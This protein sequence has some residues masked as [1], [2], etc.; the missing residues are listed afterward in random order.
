MISTTPMVD[1]EGQHQRVEKIWFSSASRRFHHW[2]ARS[3]TPG[4][5]SDYVSRAAASAVPR[6]YSVVSQTGES[7]PLLSLQRL[8]A[9]PE[10]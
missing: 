6:L 8:V 2:I 10:W 1:L 4:L 9:P 7:W 5:P 3:E